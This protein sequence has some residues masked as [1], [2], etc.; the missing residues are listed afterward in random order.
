MSNTLNNSGCGG[1]RQCGY[2][3]HSPPPYESCLTF[4]EPARIP[5]THPITGVI[6]LHSVQD[7]R[8]A[9]NPQLA[10]SADC[11]YIPFDTH[12]ECVIHLVRCTCVDVDMCASHVGQISCNASTAPIHKANCLSSDKLVCN[13]K[14]ACHV[15][16]GCNTT[17]AACVLHKHHCN[18]ID[19]NNSSGD[20]TTKVIAPNRVESRNH[21]A[22]VGLVEHLEYTTDA[23]PCPMA[24]TS[25]ML[26]TLNALRMSRLFEGYLGLTLE[27]HS[28]TISGV[29]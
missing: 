4:V 27:E 13:D 20:T 25:N 18:N 3:H 12:A 2:P 22:C 7:V 1:A 15:N 9:E 19:I 8:A 21:V 17:R 24:N 14:H 16:H 26:N 28:S 5:Q 29:F 10:E 6:S 23:P 11:S